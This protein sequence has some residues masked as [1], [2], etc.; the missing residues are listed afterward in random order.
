M[1]NAGKKGNV[2]MAI[3]RVEKNP[4]SR[5][6][7]GNDLLARAGNTSGKSVGPKLA[8][9]KKVHTTY[10]AAEKAVMQTTAVETTALQA[11]ANADVAQDAAVEALAGALIGAGGDRRNPFKAFGF[12]SPSAIEQL[13]YAAEAKRVK[14]L[15]TALPTA[16]PAPVKN[17]AK[18]LLA[19]AGAVEKAIAASAK[20][21][22]ARTQA[23]S[24]RHALDQGWETAYAGVKNAARVAE[25]DGAKGLFASLFGTAKARP[26]KKKAKAAAPGTAT[27]TAAGK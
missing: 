14:Q 3:V 6:A 4:S 2:A 17:A 22:A 20:P 26:K 1:R 15:V 24:A 25:D 16:S 7:A 10:L 8:A 9:F 21:T 12:E 19:S 27:A 13:G 23:L 5:I 18:K 11:V